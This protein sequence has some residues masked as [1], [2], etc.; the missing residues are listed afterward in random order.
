MYLPWGLENNI[1]Y[2]K[3]DSIDIK[4]SKNRT[5]VY[6]VPFLIERVLDFIL[7]LLFL[8]SSPELTHD[9]EKKKQSYIQH[10]AEGVFVKRNFES[11]RILHFFS[12]RLEKCLIGG[13]T[14]HEVLCSLHKFIP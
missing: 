7:F 3:L 13:C 9:L 14:I 2:R 8:L 1:L 10:S 4:L 6:V 11:L 5:N 12:V